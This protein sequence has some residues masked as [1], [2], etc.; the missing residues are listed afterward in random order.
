MVSRCRR[1]V[2]RQCLAVRVDLELHGAAVRPRIS[3]LPNSMLSVGLGAASA[4]RICRVVLGDRDR[5]NAV[6]EASCLEDIAE[7][8]RDHA[9]M[10]KSGASH[11][12]V[13][14]SKP[15]PNYHP[16]P[17]FWRWRGRPAVWEAEIRFSGRHGVARSRTAPCQGRARMV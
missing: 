10:P 13:L 12:R 1:T 16:R 4:R 5:Q 6:L 14:G 17:E 3:C 15:Q 9:T 2:I 11:G 7:R 8:G